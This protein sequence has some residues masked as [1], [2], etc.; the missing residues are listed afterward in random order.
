MDISQSLGRCALLWTMMC[1]SDS[2]P[3]SA[4][5]IENRVDKPKHAG[6]DSHGTWT[7]LTALQKQTAVYNSPLLTSFLR[8]WSFFNNA[9]YWRRGRSARQLAL[10]G[11][12]PPCF[13]SLLMFALVV[14]VVSVVVV[15]SY[16]CT[17]LAYVLP[18]FQIA[19]YRDG[20]FICGGSLIEPTW[21]VTA[22][23]CVTS[24][25]VTHPT[26]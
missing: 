26:Y 14:V 5:S 11:E 16:F 13:V 20:S 2:L 1:M 18:C 17:S 7:D 6:Y 12:L 15:L 21:V 23:H 10:A 4:L 22:A 19:L 3:K 9:R 8:L 25:Y 24:L